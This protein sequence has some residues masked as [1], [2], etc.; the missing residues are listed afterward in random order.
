ME[1]GAPHRARLFLGDG[2]SQPRVIS[3]AHDALCPAQRPTPAR[4]LRRSTR[5]IGI[6]NRPIGRHGGCW[7][8]TTTASIAAHWLGCSWA[9]AWRER[10]RQT[11]RR[12]WTDVAPS[13][14]ATFDTALIDMPMPTM[15]GR[16]TASRRPPCRANAPGSRASSGGLSSISTPDVARE[17]SAAGYAHCVAKPLRKAELRHAILGLSPSKTDN[18]T[19]TLKV[20]QSVWGVED[21]PAS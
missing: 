17:A 2:S 11:G 4:T 18:S 16:W 8:L 19:P 5:S 14:A 13:K 21:N 15:D 10:W 6:W 20:H 7:R 12:L 9:A 1:R 3:A